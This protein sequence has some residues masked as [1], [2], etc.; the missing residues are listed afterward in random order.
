MFDHLVRWVGERSLA[1]LK[2]D[3]DLTESLRLSNNGLQK[4]T[5]AELHVELEGLRPPTL[6]LVEVCDDRYGD[7]YNE[8]YVGVVTSK[9]AVT[10]FD[11]RLTI[12]K[13]REVNLPSLEALVLKVSKGRYR[14]ML[15]DAIQGEFM[16]SVLS[17]TLSSRVIE[18]L[19]ADSANYSALDAAAFNL[20]GLNTTSNPEWEQTDAIQMAM[21]AFGISKSAIA[22]TIAVR[23]GALSTIGRIEA[24]VLK[25][26]SLEKIPVH[27][28]VSR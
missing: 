6:C 19:A 17:P 1:I 21:A 10:T 20:P 12:I 27:C 14:N 26:M 15:R 18:I 7:D 24:H 13:L 5:F 25:T 3:S 23:D 4:F 28:P 2:L 8:C 11:S 16:V 9:A 22:K